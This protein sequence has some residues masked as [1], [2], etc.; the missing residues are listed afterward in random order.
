MLMASPLKGVE[1]RR[2]ILLEL[3]ANLIPHNAVE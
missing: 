3:E 2:N 1:I